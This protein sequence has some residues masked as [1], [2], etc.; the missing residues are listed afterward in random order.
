[1]LFKRLPDNLKRTPDVAAAF[2]LLQA[3]WQK[4]YQACRFLMSAQ[5]S[6]VSVY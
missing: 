4:D 3:L 2:T 1:M 5:N 6:A